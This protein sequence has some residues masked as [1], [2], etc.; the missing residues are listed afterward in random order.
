MYASGCRSGI[1]ESSDLIS[2]KD[3]ALQRQQ[4]MCHTIFDTDMRSIVSAWLAVL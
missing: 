2:L 1:G 3:S 4:C